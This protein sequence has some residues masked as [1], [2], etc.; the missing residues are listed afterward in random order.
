MTLF[1][2]AVRTAEFALGVVVVLSSMTRAKEIAALPRRWLLRGSLV[3]L[4]DP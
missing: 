3:P 1:H 4:T 2:I